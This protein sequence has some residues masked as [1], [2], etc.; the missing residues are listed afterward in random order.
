MIRRIVAVL[1]LCLLA[2][3]PAGEAIAQT[4]EASAR[5]IGWE[6]LVP[7]EG[8]VPPVDP[9]E[10]LS[11]W[12]R[13]DLE[14]AVETF[15]AVDA[16]LLPQGSDQHAMAQQIVDSL[17]ADGLDPHRLIRD[18]AALDAARAA[19]QQAINPTMDGQI[20]QLPGY[21]LPLS[22]DPDTVGAFLLLPFVGACI[23]YPPPP[24]NQ[25]IRAELAMP[26]RFTGRYQS[27]W[28]TGRLRAQTTTSQL[29]YVDG[30]AEVSAAWTIEVLS[31]KSYAQGPRVR[32]TGGSFSRVAAGPD[33][34]ISRRGL[35]HPPISLPIPTE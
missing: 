14:Y 35:P 12:V 25:V 2:A 22:A 24:A 17:A 29:S 32:T 26:H 28:I 31:I 33:L 16:G 23:H 34:Q 27:V 20:V 8:A 4:T 6:M 15:A 3:T 30:R 11:M 7:E 9:F 19:A 1:S 10:G 18:M 5:T 13:F 21:A